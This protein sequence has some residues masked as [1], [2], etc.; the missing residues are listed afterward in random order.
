[1]WSLSV[2][3]GRVGSVPRAPRLDPWMRHAFLFA[4]DAHVVSNPPIL[5]WIF[6]WHL[7]APRHPC[8]RALLQRLAYDPALRRLSK[9]SY[10]CGK[11]SFASTHAPEPLLVYVGH[12]SNVDMVLGTGLTVVIHWC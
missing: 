5:C 12:G 10:Y 8:R 2:G 7:G 6:Q 4:A 3:G 9:H 11:V 1:M